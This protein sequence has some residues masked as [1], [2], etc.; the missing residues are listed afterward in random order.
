MKNAIYKLLLKVPILRY[1]LGSFV[2]WFLILLGTLTGIFALLY[3]TGGYAVLESALDLKYNSPF[4]TT[5]IIVFS[6][7]ALLCFVIGCLLYFYQYKR[8]GVESK[9]Y[10]A[11]SE[12]LNKEAE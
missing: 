10:K 12:I 8:S 7:L 2:K 9:F 5:P 11:F 3:A 1:I 4:I 6:G